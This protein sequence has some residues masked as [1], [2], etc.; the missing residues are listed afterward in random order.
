[1][2]LPTSIKNI[3]D[4]IPAAVAVVDDQMNYIM[5]SQKWKTFFKLE[6]QDIIGKSHHD[7]FPNLTTHWR[8]VNNDAL[9]GIDR[10][11]EADKFEFGDGTAGWI[12]WETKHWL[13]DDGSIGGIIMFMEDVTEKVDL[14][15]KEK[16]FQLFMD[17]L[18]A[19]C[20]ITNL[21]NELKYANNSYFRKL[22]LSPD[23]VGKPNQEI[24]GDAIAE[25]SHLHDIDVLNSGESK[26]YYQTIRDQQGHPQYLK[27]YK[28]PIID[29]ETGENLIGAI[30]FD[31]TKTKLLEEEL[32]QSEEQF[33]QAFEHSQLGMAI[34]S[35]K[36]ILVRVNN[37]FAEMLG[38]DTKELE[39]KK[40]N[41]FTHPGDL[42]LSEHYLLQLQNQVV[43]SV[44]VEK[45]YIHKNG[46]FIWVIVA[47][48][49]LKDRLGRPLH[50]V[51][52]IEDITARREI[53]DNLS[54]SEKK[55][56]S[57]FENVQ[58]VFYQTN[59]EGIVT[60]ISPSIETHSGFTREEVIGQ[61]VGDFYYYPQDRE[62][63]VNT[64]AENGSVIDFEVRLK[65]KKNEIRYVSVNAR[66]LIENGQAAGVDG[67]M[68][69][70]TTRKFQEIA[71]IAL[72][73]ELTE[74]NEQKNKL[75]SIIG[76]DLRNPISGSLQLLDLTLED[77]DACATEELRMYLSQMRLELSNAYNLLEDL[78][79]W[80]KSQF[81]S[82][83]FLPVK[84]NDISMQIHKS[85]GTLKPMADKKGIKIHYNITDPLTFYADLGMLDA[86]LR[87]LLTNAIKFTPE[88]GNIYIGVKA[89]EEEVLFSI[90]D[91]GVGMS[92]E[93]L[94]GLFNFS[95][96][97]STYGTA[98]EKGSGLGLNICQ[99]FVLK[100]QGRIWAES[101]PQ[102]GSTFFFTIL[103]NQEAAV[104]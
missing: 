27:T 82:L 68:R 103:K 32:Y 10:K 64:L 2:S 47:A 13:K 20:W 21:Q 97:V 100:H 71:L 96:L 94:S 17:Y 26:V 41:D 40:I 62:R 35:R 73:T 30:S 16:R 22:H 85:L 87:N 39:G 56:R 15:H 55:Y 1:M 98:G 7:I 79:S 4:V 29:K 99:D 53:E 9:R 28:F 60:E 43:E 54:L 24:F 93:T 44:K 76:H 80:A 12:K 58:D 33:K 37:R 90:R 78:L 72:N 11:S 84:I 34:V 92:E 8:Q 38:Y 42:A 81:N 61:P 75:L 19:L 101:T 63:I 51:S 31:I 69:D 89:L 74:S 83:S 23:V 3:I 77:L 104:D 14:S 70:V 67:S 48:T 50:F 45:R 6:D 88:G 65:T 18:P 46:D 102:Q 57:I 91:N 49:M 95:Q 25:R 52:Q 5:A 36:G 66:L 86:I 59:N